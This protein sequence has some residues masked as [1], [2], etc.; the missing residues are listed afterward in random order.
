GRARIQRAIGLGD[1]I[2]P[3]LVVAA[4]RRRRAERRDGGVELGDLGVER[5]DGGRVAGGGCLG[6]LLRERV[7]LLLQ[8]GELRGI[9]RDGERQDLHLPRPLQPPGGGRTPQRDP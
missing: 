1:E 3:F 7:T 9:A 4:A 5:G 8:G 6:A 2:V